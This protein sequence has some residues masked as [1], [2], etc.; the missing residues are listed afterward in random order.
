MT[1]CT[2]FREDGRS[3]GCGLACAWCAEQ[4]G[5]AMCRTHAVSCSGRSSSLPDVVWS[6]RQLHLNKRAAAAAAGQMHPSA[7]RPP[8][9]DGGLRTRPRLIVGTA[10]QARSRTLRDDAGSRFQTADEQRIAAPSMTWRRGPET[11]RMS[12]GA[13]RALRPIILAVSPHF[14]G[15]I[16]PPAA[17]RIPGALS[18]PL[19]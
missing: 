12:S 2:V 8:V 3:C 10:L 4:A 14:P 17:A 7:E 18:L 6:Y 1:R 9:Q 11:L 15:P 13:R 16:T 5:L 19:S